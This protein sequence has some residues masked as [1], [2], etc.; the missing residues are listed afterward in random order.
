[1]IQIFLVLV[2]LLFNVVIKTVILFPHDKLIVAELCCPSICTVKNDVAVWLLSL[3]VCLYLL[4]VSDASNLSYS[5]I[6][7]FPTVYCF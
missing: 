2:V 6:D 7:I 4:V 5:C 1:M 3:E